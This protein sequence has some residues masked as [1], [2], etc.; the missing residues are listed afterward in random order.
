[1]IAERAIVCAGSVVTRAV[2]ANAIF[3][4]GAARVL[5]YVALGMSVKERIGFLDVLPK[6]KDAID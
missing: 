2:P 4:G 6:G 1:V 3:A 5:R